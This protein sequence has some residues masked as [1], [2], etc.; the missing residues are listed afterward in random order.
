MDERRTT[1]HDACE[2]RAGPRRKAGAFAWVAAFMLLMPTFAAVPA[3]A[4]QPPTPPDDRGV[5]PLPFDED[6][7][8][9]DFKAPPVQISEPLVF[10]HGWS[11]IDGVHGDYWQ[12]M[13]THLKATY[14]TQYHTLWYTCDLP[15]PQAEGTAVIDIARSPGGADPHLRHHG[16]DRDDTYSGGTHKAFSIGHRCANDKILTAPVDQGHSKDHTPL[17]HVAY[18]FAW[19]LAETFGSRCIRILAHSMGGTVVRYAL[20]KVEQ[21]DDDFPRALCVRNVMTLN[22][23]HEGTRESY[24]AQGGA[25]HARSAP[26]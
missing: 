3:G 15:P 4:D 26:G 25:R 19:A 16:T 18:H 17:E 10:V 7:H 14:P 9:R 13:D 24:C 1:G 11:A 21:E 22:S 23:P 12:G 5:A 8:P 6:D 2:T 20:Q